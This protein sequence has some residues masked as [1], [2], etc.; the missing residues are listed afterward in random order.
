M[1]FYTKVKRAYNKYSTRS[2][3]LKREPEVDPEWIL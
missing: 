3:G 2:I 1:I